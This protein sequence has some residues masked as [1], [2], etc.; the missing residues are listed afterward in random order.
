MRTG[1][2]NC[3]ISSLRKNCCIS[4]NCDVTL[5]I[6]R[7]L[8]YKPLWYHQYYH[9]YIMSKLHLAATDISENSYFYWFS[10]FIFKTIT[11]TTEIHFKTTRSSKSYSAKLSS[12]MQPLLHNKLLHTKI[13][14]SFGARQQTVFQNPVWL[15]PTNDERYVR[16]Q[17]DFH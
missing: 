11:Y 15:R 7:V 3:N 14:Q 2:G 1:R 6:E 5:T 17:K 13:I 9:T 12:V 8:T 4:I 10:V 16:K